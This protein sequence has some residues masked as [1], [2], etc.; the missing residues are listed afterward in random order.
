[1]VPEPA[2][3]VLSPS[4]VSSLVNDLL[5]LILVCTVDCDRMGTVGRKTKRREGSRVNV[6]FKF[7]DMKY[8]MYPHVRWEIKFVRNRADLLNDFIWAEEGR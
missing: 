7:R 4:V 5:D 1:M 6:S 8:R 2:D 3:E